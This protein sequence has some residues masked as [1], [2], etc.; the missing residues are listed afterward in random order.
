[1]IHY[2]RQILKIIN[3]SSVIIILYKIIGYHREN[4]YHNFIF[5]K[6]IVVFYE[7]CV[8]LLKIRSKKYAKN[9]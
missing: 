7:I 6:R 4:R 1:M 9:Y 8:I 5:I 3:I 2:D